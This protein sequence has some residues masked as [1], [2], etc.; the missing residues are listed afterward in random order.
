MNAA[1]KISA[2]ILIAAVVCVYA[3]FP[4]TTTISVGDAGSRVNEIGRLGYGKSVFSLRH[5]EDAD[6]VTLKPSA[7]LIGPG[8]YHLL[9]W[10]NERIDS[11]TYFRHEQ[12]IPNTYGESHDV[13]QV[14]TFDVKRPSSIPLFIGVVVL[15]VAGLLLTRFRRTST[16]LLVI[17]SIFVSLMLFSLSI[18]ADTLAIL[19]FLFGVAWIAAFVLGRS[20]VG[21]S[22]TSAELA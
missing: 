7:F 21:R 3:I 9:I 5:M 16:A 6:G 1:T 10:H 4:A 2:S 14:E 22:Q 8:G 19:P 15:G 11:M 12:P 20:I 18:L 17:L 13:K